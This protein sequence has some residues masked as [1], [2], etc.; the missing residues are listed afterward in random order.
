MRKCSQ[1]GKEIDNEAMGFCP[2]CGT[3]LETEILNKDYTPEQ[4]ENMAL[5]ELLV[6]EQSSNNSL[7]F[8]AIANRYYDEDDLKNAWEYYK[9]AAY[10]DE[11]VIH[12]IYML[13]LFSK[14]SLGCKQDYK[15]A[16]KC[17]KYLYDEGS[18]EV[19]TD[20]AECYLFG[21]GNEKDEKKAYEILETACNSNT[22]DGEVYRLLG[23]CKFNGIGTLKNKE[24]AYKLFKEAETKGSDDAVLML[25]LCE[26]NGWGTKKNKVEGFMKLQNLYGKYGDAIG[27]EVFEYLGDC[28]AFGL[29]CTKDLKKAFEVYEKGF[30]KEDPYCTYRIG[31]FYYE[32]KECEK[33]IE[34]AKKLIKKAA[35][36]G[37]ENAIKWIKRPE[38][39]RFSTSFLYVLANELT[40]GIPHIIRKKVLRNI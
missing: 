9:K 33:D 23:Y 19:T 22:D 34:Y 27:S 40:F 10:S 5:E 25:A 7:V 14:D 4:L 17:F 36:A 18:K 3:K 16:L 12:S 20:L 1:C 13:G 2:D 30:N 37:D 24:S 21:N 28:Y 29:G 11:P 15:E 31:C 6:L 39:R 32:G 35:D 8:D 38:L 26:F